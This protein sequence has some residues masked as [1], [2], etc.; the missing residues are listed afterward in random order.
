M[1]LVTAA[2]KWAMSKAEILEEL[3]K[4][5]PADLCEIHERIWVLQEQQLLTGDSVVTDDEKSLLDEELADYAGTKEGGDD[6][7]EVESRLKN[8]QA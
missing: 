8:R 4:L 3:P 1:R 2:L 7:G 6:W 5:N